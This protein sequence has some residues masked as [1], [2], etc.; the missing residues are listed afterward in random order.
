MAS[1]W[2]E[3]YRPDGT[4][5]RQGGEI[6]AIKSNSTGISRNR[7]KRLDELVAMQT[8]QLAKIPRSEPELDRP[9][10]IAC[11]TRVRVCHEAYGGSLDA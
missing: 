8:E 11:K 4:S 6:G 7:K 3:D 5:R 9:D 10:A 2:S 1:E